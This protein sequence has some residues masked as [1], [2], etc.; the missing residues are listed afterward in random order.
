ML[1][2]SDKF[3][4]NKAVATIR[5]FTESSVYP[6]VVGT[7]AFLCYVFSLPLLAVAFFALAL[8]FTYAFSEDT[9]AA[10]A[11]ALLVFLTLQY[12]RDE[13][14]YLTPFAIVIYVIF[15]IIAVSAVVFHFIYYKLDMTPKKLLL[16]LILMCVTFFT[17]GVFSGYYRVYNLLNGFAMAGMFCGAYILFA[18]TMRHRKDNFL[19]IARLC[20]VAVVVISLEVFEFYI[21][22]YKGGALTAYWK[23]LIILGWG[24]S[25]LVGEM[26]A[27]LLPAVFYL[28]YR[29]KRGYLYYIVVLIAGVALFLTLGRNALLFGGIVVFLGCVFNAVKG[30]NSKINLMI[31][32]SMLG[33]LCL[34]LLIMLITGKTTAL[35]AF[36]R[37]AKWSD[38]G[39]FDCWRKFAKLFAEDPLF[40][41]GIM[42]YRILYPN[43]YEMNTHN[44]LLQMLSNSGLIGL[45][46]Y[47]FHRFQTILMVLKKP[48]RDIIFVGSC[49][50]VGLVMSLLS[51]LFFRMYF[52][53]F[54][55]I[56]LV[57]IEKA[58]QAETEN[59]Q[60]LDESVTTNEV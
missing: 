43:S 16:G 15:G 10:L 38:R 11:P 45:A 60:E 31:A 20:A 8:A 57:V 5:A 21:R 22:E 27:T 52:A 49:V 9:R 24:I 17:G 19:Y 44:T 2:I 37:T 25:N 18:F 1:K 28:I 46:L 29:E 59:K 23:G 42:K 40:G 3:F 54:Y 26:I 39:R 6:I 36:F 35:F 12:K 14:A 55:S 56:F 50:I 7:V 33:V 41:A 34:V 51:P 30:K 47:G 48:N 58:T 32:L 13:A 53:I 4:N